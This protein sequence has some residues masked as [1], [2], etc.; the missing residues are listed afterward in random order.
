MSALGALFGGGGGGP[1]EG[2]GD[3][4]ALL[5]EILSLMEQYLAMGP[6]TPAFQTIS[7]A[8]PAIQEAM[9]GGG[10]GEMLPPGEEGME[11][12][13]V[14]DEGMGGSPLETMM[15]D[16]PPS[17]MEDASAMALEDMKKRRPRP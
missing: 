13:P 11:G 7:E 1:E 9:G 8:M 17:S 5:S 10:E 12:P 2:G 6:E 14:E 16:S 15:P 3:P 4:E